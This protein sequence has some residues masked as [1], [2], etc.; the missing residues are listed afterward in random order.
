[1]EKNQT[2]K[3][4]QYCINYKKPKCKITGEFVPRKGKC[5]NESEHFKYRKNIKTVSIKKNK[6]TQQLSDSDL[7][8]QIL[9]LKVKS[10]ETRK[11]R[12]TKQK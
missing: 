1:M 5:V 7:K 10:P 3:V 2:P 6:E 8:E 9:G 4:C 11:P 12:R